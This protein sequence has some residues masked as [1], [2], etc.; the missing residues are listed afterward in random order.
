M[1]TEVL[2]PM[3]FWSDLALAGVR[4][5]ANGLRLCAEATTRAA[6]NPVFPAPAIRRSRQIEMWPMAGSFGGSN[7]VA[8]WVDATQAMMGAQPR[9]PGPFGWAMPN[10]WLAN[11]SPGWTAMLPWTRALGWPAPMFRMP[12]TPAPAFA[13]PVKMMGLFAPMLSP[14]GPPTQR[15]FRYH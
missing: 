11:T 9:L 4:A 7:A 8:A 1:P 13:D 12:F 3:T 14:F 2:N 15:S 5:Y 10:P 6:A